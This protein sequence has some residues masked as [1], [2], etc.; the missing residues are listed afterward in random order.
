MKP[1]LHK[2]MSLV[3][4]LLDELEIA[5]CVFDDDDR[6][7]YW[8]QSLLAFFP[9]H[10][11]RIHEG[12]P[13]ADNLRRFY[14]L[15]LQGAELSR[16]DDY[17]AAG[18]QRHRQQSKAYE[19]EHRG[20]M[21]RV[22]ARHLPMIGRVRMWRDTGPAPAKA[23]AGTA[24]IDLPVTP[25]LN[26][27]GRAILDELPDGLMICSDTGAIL[28]VNDA[29]TR[30]YG[31]PNRQAAYNLSLQD[32]FRIA[33]EPFANYATDR[34]DAGLQTLQEHLRFSGAPF[35]VQLPNHRYV[36]ITSRV[37]HAREMLFTHVDITEQKI[38]QIQL[39]RLNDKLLKSTQLA[40]EASRSK[41]MFLATMSHEIRT[42][43]NGIVGMT[44]L[45]LEGELSDEQRDSLN[46]ALQSS[47]ALMAIINDILDLSKIEAGQMS[48]ES[49]AFDPREVISGTLRTLSFNAR[50]KGI[51][52]E[53]K[54]ADAVPA[55]LMGDP[56]R[57]RQ[58]LLNLVG[59]AIKFTATGSVTVRL[60]PLPSDNAA[61]VLRF[62]VQD[63]G[64]GIP[65]DKVQ[66]IFLPF[67]QADGSTTRQYGGT[68]L[69]LTI[70]RQLV[71]L[72]GG[73]IGVD[74]TLGQGSTFHFSARFKPVAAAEASAH[75]APTQASLPRSLNILLVEDHPVNQ[76]LALNTLQRAG[77]RV[78]V[79][80]SGADGLEQ[81]RQER[82]DLIL[83]DVQMP[84]MDGLEATRRI[85]E[86]EAKE[87]LPRTPIVAMTANAFT[88]DREACLAAGMDGYLSKPVRP[89][90]MLRAVM[91][92]MS[93]VN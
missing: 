67:S 66:Q 43:M 89:D 22:T 72:M 6:S 30:M 57:L 32:V 42:P 79:A 20:R 77:H 81:W 10:S 60:A 51:A 3:G 53:A 73:H 93:Q 29:F 54:V 46:V 27:V 39:A 62:E 74:S 47:Q 28:W 83:M 19:Y 78:R 34:R 80:A 64:I 88:E 21:I 92:P 61:C 41:S 17:I 65:A 16:I 59:N 82:P 91:A 9:E 35:E 13:Y 44:S 12:E 37:A 90:V 52:L 14:S 26:D 38:Q 56:T 33:W 68:G 50:G 49:I 4:Q 63:T 75:P 55:R 36:R 69:G 31:L 71:E 84:V 70:S 23:A 45:A 15:R 85:R 18:I 40:E 24:A 25:A 87:Q 1:R 11:G 5:I 86:A 48:L 76:M 58:I 8:N 2:L 7:Q